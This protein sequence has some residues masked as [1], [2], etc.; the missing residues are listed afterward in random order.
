MKRVTRTLLCLAAVTII[1][2]CQTNK[3]QAKASI[4]A[5]MNQQAAD[6]SNGNI[7]GYMNGYWKSDSL[8]FMGRKG[9]T[10]GWTSTLEK[11]KKSYP[12]KE[13]MGKLKFNYISF[14]PI[15]NSMLVIGKWTITYPNDTIGGY[16]SLIWKQINGQW[17][18]VLDHT[19]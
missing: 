4:E 3:E 8:R 6:W 5:I 18:I 7:E 9:I 11:Y 10:Y 12:T 17:K 2:S 13:A 15:G 14:E 16:Y 19:S 1:A